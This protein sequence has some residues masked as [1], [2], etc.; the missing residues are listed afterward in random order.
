MRE[1]GLVR[2]PRG[3]A[4][5]SPPRGSVTGR[6]VEGAVPLTTRDIVVRSLPSEEPREGYGLG[7]FVTMNAHTNEAN[8]NAQSAKAETLPSNASSRLSLTS[9][10]SKLIMGGKPKS[11]KKGKV[12]LTGGFITTVQQ[13]LKKGQFFEV[14]SMFNMN[15]DLLE[16]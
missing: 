3:R 12:S 7:G 13:C 11:R 2:S 10:N 6:S 16:I 14:I 4:T 5:K 1:P 8:T 15:K 9:I